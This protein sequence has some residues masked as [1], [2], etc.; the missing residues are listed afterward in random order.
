MVLVT[1]TVTTS[2]MAMWSAMTRQNRNLLR[3][4]EDTLSYRTP[5]LRRRQVLLAAWLA[6]V[7]S[8]MF[9][10][11]SCVVWK[12]S[13]CKYSTVGAIS[14]LKVVIRI[15]DGMDTTNMEERYRQGYTFIS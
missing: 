10:F 7:H 3:W 6:M 12:N 14:C 8:T 1:S 5:L 11:R 2:W 9:S 13:K 15:L 4:M